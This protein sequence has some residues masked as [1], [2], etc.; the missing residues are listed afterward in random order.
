VESRGVRLDR[1]LSH[2]T[3]AQR[4]LEGFADTHAPGPTVLAARKVSAKID[5]VLGTQYEPG[6][7]ANVGQ[8]VIASEILC[9][10]W[11]HFADPRE[12][13]DAQPPGQR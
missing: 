5:V 9:R 4:R 11:H 12:S 6:A 8:Q 1:Q 10:P 13:S 2:L 7:S 3:G